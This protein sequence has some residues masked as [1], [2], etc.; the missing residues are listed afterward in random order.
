MGGGPQ[1]RAS[2]VVKNL[3]KECKET[4]ITWKENGSPGPDSAYFGKRKE[5]KKQLRRQLR[6]ENYLK[7]EAF[8]SGLMQN[9]DT[10]TFYRLIKMN[11]TNRSNS[12]TC[13]IING[14]SI[15]D[16]VL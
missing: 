7:K 3:L 9:P 13:F 16:P 8:N 2:P 5:A 1:F 4:H 11:Q 15:L 10:K 14:K 12:S 6:K